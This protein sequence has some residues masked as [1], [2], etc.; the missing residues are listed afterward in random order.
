GPDGRVTKADVETFRRPA[1]SRE[2]TPTPAPAPA[3]AH[4]LAHPD[5]P[6]DRIPFVGLRRKI[7]QKMAQSKSTA[8]HY[9]FVEECDATALKALRERLRAPAEAHGVKLSFLPF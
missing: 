8:A 7:A 2:P 3:P 6:P 1:P 9:T 4:A 5:P